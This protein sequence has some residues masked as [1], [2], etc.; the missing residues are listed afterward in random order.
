[1]AG[2]RGTESIR[3][4][5]PDVAGGVVE[6]IPVRREGIHRCGADE[7]VLAGVVLGEPPLED[8]HAVLATRSQLV[9]PREP[10]TVY[11]TASLNARCSMRWTVAVVRRPLRATHLTAIV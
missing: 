8:V 6:A 9:A 1:M 11:A 4:P 10:G 2:T 7:A 3:T 5:L